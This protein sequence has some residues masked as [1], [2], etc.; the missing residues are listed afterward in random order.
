MIAVIRV[1][2]GV[3]LKKE[4]KDTLDKLR[5]Y[6]K[7]FCVVVEDT[8]Q[9]KG[10]I[11]KVKD[12]VTFGEITDELYSELIQKRGTEYKGRIQD[13]RGKINYSRKFIDFNDKK[14][15]KYFRLAPPKKGYEKKGTKK[16]FSKGGA[17]GN[18]KSKIED[19]LRRMM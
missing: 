7:N 19:L 5:L 4:V 11:N 2:G 14:Y 10:M 16:P 6:N 13:S 12:F 9:I 3:K 15:N 8:P 1:R 18:R 17:L